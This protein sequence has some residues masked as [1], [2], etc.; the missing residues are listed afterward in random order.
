VTQPIRILFVD[1]H[2]LFRESVIRLLEREAAFTIAGHCS[3]LSEA[4]Q[5]LRSTPTD[6]VLLDYDLGA[7][8][9]TDILN[10][11]RRTSPS[12]KVL[13]VTGGMGTS[14]I[15]N[16]VDAGI[17]GIILKHSDPRQLME[18]IRAIG[19]GG[20]W[21]DPAALP[22]AQHATSTASPAEAPRALTDRQ[23]HVL[24]S[25]LDGLSNKEI[26]ARLKVS[27]SAIKGSIQEL[28]LKAGVR[29]RSQLVRVAIER[30]SSDWLQQ[31]R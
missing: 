18:A 23:R 31:I 6:V 21:W 19:A 7:E 29:T 4:R 22:S 15:L 12:T 3:S 25:I 2:T 24:R 8:L 5:I 17:S 9:G 28:F 16:A 30:Y 26:A 1:D 27:E 10:D 13:I 11:L 20:S 14:A